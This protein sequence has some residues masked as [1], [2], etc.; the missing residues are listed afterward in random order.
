MIRLPDKNL[1]KT[2]AFDRERLAT[3]ELP[4]ITVAGTFREDIKRLYGLP[5]NNISRDTVFSRAHFSMALAIADQVWQGEAKPK[6]AWLA[7]PTNYVSL[8]DWQKIIFT[9]L[10][11]Q[12][13]A[14]HSL[15]HT[16]KGVIDQFGRD[17]LPILDSITPPLL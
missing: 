3:T 17:K 5:N 7:D 4:I 9:E 15:L 10:V 8:E 2:F 11:G 16:L 14:R 12:T 1:E 13:I 6:K